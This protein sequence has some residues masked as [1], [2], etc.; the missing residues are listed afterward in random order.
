MLPPLDDS[1]A[2]DEYERTHDEDGVLIEEPAPRTETERR[3]L[4]EET[5]GLDR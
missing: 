5:D 1:E 3:R 2:L 4:R